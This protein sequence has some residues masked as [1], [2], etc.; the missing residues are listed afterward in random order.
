MTGTVG[1]LVVQFEKDLA[2]PTDDVCVS[3]QPIPSLA[4]RGL[5]DE[6]HDVRIAVILHDLLGCPPEM[7]A[8]KVRRCAIHKEQVRELS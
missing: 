6:S 3:P 1:H 8:S 5:V 7:R 2:A 4:V